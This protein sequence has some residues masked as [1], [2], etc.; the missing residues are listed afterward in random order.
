MLLYED[1]TYVHYII[2]YINYKVHAQS[3]AIRAYANRLMDL[4]VTVLLEQYLHLHTGLYCK[5]VNIRDFLFTVLKEY[6]SQPL[7]KV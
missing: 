2:I 6:L 3:H 5:L 4:K 1:H 7:T